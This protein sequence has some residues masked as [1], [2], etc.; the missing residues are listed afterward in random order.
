MN[1]AKIKAQLE[2]E[3]LIAIIRLTDPNQ[4]STVLEDLVEGGIKA[5][6]ITS[7]TPGFADTITFARK[8]FEDQEVL[9][10]A[11]TI[12]DADL[13]QTAIE[14]GAQFLVTPNT[15]PEILKMA[16]LYDIPVVMGA[17][18]PTEICWALKH[19]ADLIKLFPA[20]SLGIDY[21]KAIRGPLSETRFFVVG[22]IG[23]KN[24]ENW[25]AAGASGFGLGSVLTQPGSRE[26]R[27]E[28]ARQFVNMTKKA[29]WIN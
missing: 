21:F 18:T 27:I 12:T 20:E 24:F 28:R 29:S 9:I 25:V 17:L 15:D 14:A 6:E 1:R 23:L 4:V 22:G 19:G 11:G 16:H 2:K 8:H 3:R 13:A 10:G 7:N 5:L 26:E